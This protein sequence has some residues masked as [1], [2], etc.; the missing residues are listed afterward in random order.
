MKILID[1]Q[2]AQAS[3][4]FRGVG[5]Y[6]TALAKAMLRHG[7]G[8]EFWIALNGAMYESAAELTEMFSSLLPRQRIRSFHIPTPVAEID[9]AN[10]WR[11]RAAEIMREHFLADLAPDLVHVSSLFEGIGH[12]AAT[13]VGQ[14]GMGVPT[15]VTLYDLIP[16]LNP[17]SYLVDD[18]ARAWYLRKA[19]SL[20]RADLLLAISTSSACE[21]IEALHV[22]QERIT[23]IGA[24][25]DPV[26]H[27]VTLDMA[28]E[29]QLRARYGL[30][31][32]VVLYT[33]GADPRKNLQGLINGFARLPARLRQT[34]RIAIV[35]ELGE[36]E[37]RLLHDGATSVGLGS[38]ELC[39]TGYV[40]EA[41]LIALYSICAAFVFPSFHEGFGLPAAEAMACGAPV[42][43]S[44]T[45]SISE[46]I[47]LAEALFDPHDPGDISDRLKRVLTDQAFQFRLKAHGPI[48]AGQFT[49]DTVATRA[50]DAFERLHHA[51]VAEQQMMAPSPGRM[52]NKTRPSLAFISP[53]PGACTR[54][55]D[56]AAQ[57]LPE[58]ACY[59]DI[60]CIVDQ[61]EVMDPWTLAN[62]PRRGPAWFKSNAS[63]FDRTLYCYAESIEHKYVLSLL[64]VCPGTVLLQDF[65]SPGLPTI[66]DLAAET[67][68][69]ALQ[70]LHK[71]HGLEAVA[72]AKRDGLSTALT[73]F[74]G[75][76]ELL[77]I[78]DGVIVDTQGAIDTVIR[79]Y[80]QGVAVRLWVAAPGRSLS[81]VS[82]RTQA[83][84]QLE[85]RQD[86]FVVCSFGD[87]TEDAC[88]DR[89]L[90]SWLAS[91]LSG[92]DS[93]RLIF[94]GSATDDAFGQAVAGGG[95]CPGKGRIA[96]VE[97]VTAEAHDAHLAASDLIVQVGSRRTVQEADAVRDGVHHGLRVIATG[98]N[99]PAGLPAGAVIRLDQHF[100][101][102]ELTRI[103]ER[104]R[105][106]NSSLRQLGRGLGHLPYQVRAAQEYRD[107]VEHF[108]AD[109]ER[110][111]HRRLIERLA[112][113]A[114]DSEPTAAD[115]EATAIAIVENAPS[116]GRKQ[117]LLDITVLAVRDV[118]TGIQRVTRNVA[119]ELI[120]APP[121]GYRV[122]F[123]RLADSGYV[124]ARDYASRFVG[125]ESGLLPD[126]PVELRRGDIFLGLDLNMNAPSVRPWFEA[127]RRQGVAV[128]FVVYDLLPATMPTMF[129]SEIE[130]IYRAWLTMIIEIADGL[131]CIS[132]SVADELHSWIDK[133]R[134]RLVAPLRIGWFHQGTGLGVKRSVPKLS[135]QEEQLLAD[136]N[137]RP[138]ILA[139]GSVEPR[140][141]YSQMLGAFDI[142]WKRGV[143]V[144]LVIVGIKGW[145]ME[146]LIRQLE[147]HPQNGRRLFWLS[148]ISDEMLTRFYQ[149]A[150]VL[151]A[152]SVGE[153]FGLPLVEAAQ[154]KLPIIARDLAV[155]REVAGEHASYFNTNDADGL[156]DVVS[157]WLTEHHS[158]AAP[159]ITHP[160]WLTWKQSV[161]QLL[162]FIVGD[163]SYLTVRLDE[164]PR[165]L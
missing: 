134:L 143:D 39:F 139:V 9:A 4:R 11:T 118:G 101:V 83:R 56:A 30:A 161:D 24:G 135:P 2:G 152:A 153:G 93:C 3:G 99:I 7:R 157:Q 162:A 146:D 16:L 94:V 116:F 90:A 128:F 23:T 154:C 73:R 92:D 151:L 8:H 1:L 74:P 145:M 35:G 104:L 80:G 95:A 70:M 140:K 60:T 78:A 125:L 103:L 84:A 42:I 10:A 163:V 112:R 131:L 13:S 77:N 43:G 159:V 65:P 115:L 108:A 6:T 117:I 137:A 38:D 27:P 149:T 144:S 164:R 51:R 36:E 67:S 148:G 31:R 29:A 50:L 129:G 32:G 122:E 33:G 114:S 130:P 71:M 105:A 141:G 21:A 63:S 165:P 34:H 53:L 45:T 47:G 127:M 87:P 82:N 15:A 124:Y 89:L 160:S 64:R 55:A 132:R 26:F 142:L 44:N 97:A 113:V 136:V 123:V 52:P 46:V 119:T 61:T 62:F 86:D 133:T 22:P 48:Q 150:T 28:E 156:A 138:S 68:T 41:D 72:V 58:L 75:V 37:K 49:W 121:D 110:V 91:K 155:F 57:L 88:V 19:Q 107:A 109:A 14:V 158:A 40:P 79:L 126:E 66:L 17:K 18:R 76:E 69:S 100:A 120:A 12:D 147:S 102:D 25:V 54:A 85:L 106:E 81:T 96:V 98:R 20:K 59:Y 111:G 5:R